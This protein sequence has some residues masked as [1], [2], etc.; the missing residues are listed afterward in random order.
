MSKI[1]AFDNSMLSNYKRCPRYFYHRNVEHLVASGET[2]ELDYKAQFGVAC[3]NAWDEWFGNKGEEAMNNAFLTHWLPFE[4]KDPRGIRSVERGLAMLDK[5]RKL[6]PIES[7][8]FKIR[9]I[10]VGFSCVLG[11]FI[12]CGRMDKVAEW[13]APGFEGIIIIDHKTSAAKGYLTLK[14]NA[15]LDGYIWG[16]SQI[17]GDNVVGA[18]LDQVYL[19]KTKFD[20]IRELTTRTQK[21]IELWQIE[22]LDWMNQIQIRLNMGTDIYWPRNTSACRNF[23]RDCEYKT[24]CCCK[25]DG[26][27]V[28]LKNDYYMVDEWSPYPDDGEDNEESKV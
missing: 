17:V 10:E 23:G 27:R 12:Y 22:A 4:G 6:Y 28:A 8:P 7:D 18:Y 20:F 19:Y 9:H 13:V 2:F 3:H 21:E 1:E 16:A 11:D 26:M 14:P 24:L 25:D 5:Y 15:A